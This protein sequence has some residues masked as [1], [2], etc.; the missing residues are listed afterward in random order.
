VLTATSAAYFISA[1]PATTV[2]PTV[3]R[4]PERVLLDGQVNSTFDVW[5]FGCLIYEL[6]IGSP[7]F[8]VDPSRDKDLENDHQLLLFSDILGPLPDHLYSSWTRSSRY[9]TSKRVL[10]NAFLEEVPEGTDLLSIRSK[11]LEGLFDEQ[12]PAMPDDEAKQVKSLLRRILQ[13][14]PAKRPTPAELLK[15]PWFTG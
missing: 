12:R 2:T 13:Y 10:F 5:A 9:Y 4:T 15:D 6:L 11:P 3:Y 8:Q 1:P 7:L 14:D